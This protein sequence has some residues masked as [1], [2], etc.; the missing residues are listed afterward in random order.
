MML[1]ETIPGMGGGGIKKNGGG[2]NSSM[3]YLIHCKIFCKCH[4]VT[5][6]STTKK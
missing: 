2:V 1:V 4:N 3:I 5:P 6:P